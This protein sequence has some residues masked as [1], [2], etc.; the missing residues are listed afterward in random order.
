MVVDPEAQRHPLG[1]RGL[2][3]PQ[4]PGQQHHVTGA[5]GPGQGGAQGPGV[6]GRTASAAAPG[7]GPRRAG[8]R[9]IAG[10]EPLGPDEVGAH[11][12]H[13]LGATSQPGG[14]MVRGDEVTAPER[15]GTAAH[16]AD[17]FGG[18]EQQ[19][20]GEVAQTSPRPSAPPARAGPRG[21]GGRQ[22]SR[23]GGGRG[24]R[25]GG[26]SRRWRCS[27]GSGRCRSPGARACRAACRTGPRTAPRPGPPRARGP[28]PTNMSDAWGS[29]TP[30]T[31]WVRPAANAQRVQ[32]EASICSSAR[33]PTRGMVPPPRA[34]AAGGVSRSCRR[35]P[36]SS[37][38]TRDGV[39]SWACARSGA[40]PP[41]GS[42]PARRR[43]AGRG[44]A[45]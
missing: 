25:G 41:V 32:V 14:G 18:V 26:T 5:Q 10:Q 20:G 34:R 17:A 1:H 30:N 29:P 36:R 3:R 44:A 2:A 11:L 24:C 45:G 28:P 9:S 19:A 40:A 12:R 15:V 16:A 21:R 4:V 42:G 33:V 38:R 39:R 27:T 8:S 13:H 7:R 35:T 23:R 43:C 22:R 37:G 6:L 31:T